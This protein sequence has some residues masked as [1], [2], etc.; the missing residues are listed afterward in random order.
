MNKPRLGRR[1]GLV[2]SI[3]LAFNGAVGAGIFALPGTLLADFGSFSPWLFPLVGAGALL[4]VW[5]FARSVA[6]F[7]ESGGPATYGRAFGRLPGFELGWIYY[8][9]RAAAFAAN[10]N[11][12]TA[13]VA[14]WWTGAD[15]GLARAALIVA[16]TG[17]FAAVNIA[18]VRRSLRLLGGLTVLKVLPLLLFS[19]AA[20]LLA[21]PPPSP[22][23]PPPLGALETGVL[24]VFYAF[25]GFEN[26]TVPAGETRRPETALPRAIL[27]TLAAMTLLYFLVQ[28]AFIMAL[29]GGG[30]DDKAPLIDLGGHVAGLAGVTIITL[31]V[32]AS[33][34]G[35][36]HSNLACTPRLTYAMAERG[37]LPRWFGAV[38]DRFHTPARSI[39][40]M[41]VLAAVLALSGS[42]VLLAAVSVL[43]RLF[44]YAV[45]IAALPR[46]PGR[47]RQTLS[48]WISGAFGIAV[49]VWAAA[50]ADG[51]AWT[52]LGVLAVA[53]LIL[54]AFANAF[55]IRTV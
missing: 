53:G 21:F 39:G 16:V 31:T 33:L 5:P 3:L 32:I 37:D 55:R 10:A 28:L 29:P 1:I 2:G 19:V 47:P 38:S 24:V 34:A 14:R 35:N 52:T 18:G 43:S 42:F 6:A 7:P 15:Q 17:V 36:L 11:V 50:Q 12:L 48:H 49:C 20:I 4:I 45:T 25:I 54:Y 13:Y 44:V 27:T 51:K 26:A 9:S 8:I 22:G 30:T 46:A 23:P 41:A 40:F